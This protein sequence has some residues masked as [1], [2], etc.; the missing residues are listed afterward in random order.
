MVKYRNMHMFLDEVDSFFIFSAKEVYEKFFSHNSFGAFCKVM[1]RMEQDQKVCRLARGIYYKPAQSVLGFGMVP[2]STRD[3]VRHYL[4][5]D[6]LSGVLTGY[7]LFRKYGLTTQVEKEIGLCS[8]KISSKVLK[9]KN[10][11]ICRMNGA[12]NELEKRCLEFLF[13]LHEMN[14]IEDL[15]FAELR[16]YLENTSVSVNQEAIIEALQLYHFPKRTIAQAKYIFDY[17]G[18]KHE[19]DQF[20]SP[21]STYRILKMEDLNV[22]S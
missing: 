21:V 8:N 5:E 20:L 13:I 18:V 3:I 15:D 16:H 22:F 10:V 2:I 14:D 7:S 19:L 4:G 1:S 6:G 17:F 9:L 12:M 11:S